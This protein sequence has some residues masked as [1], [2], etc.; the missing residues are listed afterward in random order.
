MNAKDATEKRT[1]RLTSRISRK[2]SD[3]NYGSLEVCHGIEIDVE[4]GRPSDL[5]AKYA[6]IRRLLEAAVMEG[7]DQY[8]E[9]P[10]SKTTATS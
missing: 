8:D 7:L 10:R 6:R 1:A 3:G 9:K 4:F 5:P 2:V